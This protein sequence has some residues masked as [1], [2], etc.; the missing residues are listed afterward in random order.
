MIARAVLAVILCG[1][2]AGLVM[3]VVQHVRL[4]P[5]IIQAETYEIE[6][7]HD[8]SAHV[9]APAA[10][11]PAEG[12]ERTV[13]TSL[14]SALAGAG[15]AALLA[16]VA[17][18]TGQNITRENGWAWGL[19]GFAAVSLAPAIGLP[20]ELPGMPAAST[21]VRQVWWVVTIAATGLGFWLIAYKRS[22]LAVAAAL[23]LMVL[24]HIIGAPQPPTG[25]SQVPAQLAA[26]FSTLSLGANALMWLVIGTLLGF[27]LPRIEL[28][29]S[30]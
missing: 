19:C 4:T 2:A 22:G 1:I 15:F 13:Y 20:P 17:F 26:S 7:G 25:Q 29:Q 30:S 5:L 3:G 24:P 14:A 9:H 27:A 23:L 16:G 10:W 12:L 28:D 11:S 8:H 21:T 6:G 18:V